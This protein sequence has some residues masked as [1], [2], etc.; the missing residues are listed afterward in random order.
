MLIFISYSHRD[1][2]FVDRL[3]SQLVY[4]KVNVW[5]DRWEMNAG[6][7]LMD[8][9]QSALTDASALL[10]ILSPHSVESEWC[11]KE[12]NS[13]L[14]RELSEKRVVIIPVLVADCEIPLFLREKMYAD[15]RSNFDEGL[16]TILEAVSKFTNEWRNRSDTPLWHTDWSIDWGETDEGYTALRL[17]LVEA[18]KGQPYSILTVVTLLADEAA[19]EWYRSEM[20]A[21]EGEGARR[22]LVNQLADELIGAE[23]RLRLTDQFPLMTQIDMSTEHGDF[24]VGISTRLLGEDTGRDVIFELSQ[25]VNGIREQMS[26]AGP[27]V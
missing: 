4:H 10:V 22:F 3:A 2:A 13:G 1:K 25:Q 7:S 8:K 27:K 12:L 23:T 26:A 20:D 14:M 19:E 15:F 16:T 6:D 18:A 17:T 5:L 21:G 9:V 11:K 24:H